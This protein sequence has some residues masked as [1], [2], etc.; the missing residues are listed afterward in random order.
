M[1]GSG[2][3]RERMVSYLAGLSPQARDMLVRNFERTDPQTL[4]DEERELLEAARQLAGAP[5]VGRAAGSP[6][7]APL[8][9]AS[10]ELRD[11]MF[12]P[13]R[14]FVI[15]ERT[16]IRQPGWI[17]HAS[18][19][20]IWTYVCREAMPDALAPWIHLP[21]EVAAQLTEE[22]DAVV[23]G[24][25]AAMF[26]ELLRIERESVDDPRGHQRFVS[27]LGGERAHG[28]WRQLV[29]LRERVGALD[30]LLAR[31]PA[32]AT[33]G[34]A[35]ERL[36]GEGLVQFVTDCPE[37]VDLL[38]VA[39]M[40]RLSNPGML[41]RIAVQ[42]AGSEDVAH[43]RTARVGPL[44]D[45]ALAAA[46]RQAVRLARALEARGDG[47]AAAAELKRFH[48]IV[49][50]VLAAVQIDHDGIWR[51]RLAALRRGAS[52]R[53]GPRI[54]EVPAAVRRAL[55][56][57]PGV[58]PTEDDCADAVRA[59][60]LF[61]A[62]RRCR[63]SLALNEM[64]ARVGPLIEHIVETHGREV[65]D[66]LRRAGPEAGQALKVASAAYVRL[67]EH[68]HGEEHAAVLRKARHSALRHAAGAG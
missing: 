9:S 17:E 68:L 38:A 31:L 62:V 2:V 19:D 30:R 47:V 3:L 41:A 26:I 65:L 60:A 46:D 16:T 64:L 51:A 53:L 37:D 6:E 21:P 25:R 23:P 13:F 40:P 4:A 27:R 36:M 11:A 61:V 49:R 66:R 18:I 20:S 52:D 28:D 55:Q 12:A 10:E 34:E 5:A 35:S 50:A 39:L 42:I 45:G 63:D 67:S 29:R 22:R 1:P 33:I 57:A 8:R 58:A 54:D 59:V 43:L 56:F 48:E 44:V 14:S 15:E 7:P 24:L 32:T